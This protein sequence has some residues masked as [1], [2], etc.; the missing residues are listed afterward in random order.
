[1]PKS[2]LTVFCGKGGVGKT[3]LSLAFGLRSA[4]AG[5]KTVVVTSHPLS[6]LAVTISLH[7]L[8]E[9]CPLAAAN[10][11]ILH[12]D[13]QE[14]LANKVRQQVPSPFL[15]QAVLSS[16]I[17]QSLVEVAPGIKE[18]AFLAR[19]R[20][21]A[22]RQPGTEMGDFDLL[23]WDAPATGHFIQ[24]LKVSRNFDTYL[25]GPF[26]L[27][28]KD[29]LEFL[30]DPGNVC[31]V[32][33]ATLEEMAV[34]ETIELCGQLSKEFEMSP[35]VVLC[36]LAS[37]LLESSDEEFGEIEAQMLADNPESEDARFILGRQVIERKLFRRLR[38]SVGVPVQIVRRE[39]EAASDLDLLSGLSEKLIGL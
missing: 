27:A 10:L 1:M 22:R 37:P 5:R 12:I 8:K 15:A 11:F 3:T 33:V 6:E 32:P 30:I 19:L 38:S 20:S 34:E 26:A 4:K 16:S 18:L 23:I 24:T 21:L 2:K 17:Y 7:G 29:M 13:A 31:L 9:Q 36:N 14:E 25:S 28:G 35:A 39:A